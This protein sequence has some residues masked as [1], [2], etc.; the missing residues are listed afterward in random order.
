MTLGFIG[1]F[2]IKPHTKNMLIKHI[3]LFFLTLILI[4]DFKINNK[5]YKKTFFIKVFLKNHNHGNHNIKHN[6]I[7]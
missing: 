6:L 3:K 1:N 2:T 5:P 4:K 7:I